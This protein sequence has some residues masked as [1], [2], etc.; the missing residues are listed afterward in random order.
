[1]RQRKESGM[2]KKAISFLLALAMVLGAFPVAYLAPQYASA[3]SYQPNARVELTQASLEADNTLGSGYYVLAEDISLDNASG[4]GLKIADDAKVYINLNGKTLEV[5]GG[6]YETTSCG[7]AGLYLPTGSSLYQIGTGSVVASGGAPLDE[8][9]GGGAAAPASNYDVNITTES[10]D[11]KAD[12]SK[13]ASGDTVMISVPE[14]TA[15]VVI[16]DANGNVIPATKVNDT[17]YTFKMP[18]SKVTVETQ[19]PAE[20]VDATKIF[21]DVSESDYYADAVSWAVTNGIT[22]GTDPGKFSP[23]GT[24]TRSQIIAFLY[25]YEKMLG[26]GFTGLWGYNLDYSDADKILDYT[27]EAFC[28]MN[29]NGI[30]QGSNGQLYP[31]DGCN[32]ADTI[33][34]MYRYFTR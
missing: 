31:N 21:V 34:L 11:I 24:L 28:F 25:R 14:G 23:N 9:Y 7:A 10:G 30:V 27:Y 20:P 32:R 13:A 18:A 19:K 22:T 16:K 17:T 4:S 26:G 29:M 15:G 33:T 12:K 2:N 6:A 1:M 5:Q 8:D 3:D